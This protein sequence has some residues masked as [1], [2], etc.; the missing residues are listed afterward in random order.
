MDRDNLGRRISFSR[1]FLLNQA[2]DHWLN[3]SEV[4]FQLFAIFAEG[5]LSVLHFWILAD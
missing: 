2:L 5:D 4:I 3:L 1:T